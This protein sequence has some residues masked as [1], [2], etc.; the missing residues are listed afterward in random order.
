[1]KAQILVGPLKVK[2]NL[3]TKMTIHITNKITLQS[4]LVER[5]YNN[6]YL[7]LSTSANSQFSE[8]L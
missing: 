1:M 4:T 2:P 8:I 6:T 5:C 7:Y 3:D